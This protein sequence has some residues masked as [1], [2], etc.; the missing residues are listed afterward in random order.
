VISPLTG[1]TDADAI[2]AALRGGYLFDIGG[3]KAGPMLG[4]RHTRTR[5]DGY[6]E[7]GDPALAILVDRQTL[8]STTSDLGAEVHVALSDRVDGFAGIAWRHEFGDEYR[9]LT[10]RLAQSPLLPIGTSVQNFEG[11]DHGVVTGGLSFDVSANMS[12]TLAGAA[13]FA[14]ESGNN[15]QIDASLG[16]RSKSVS[17]SAATRAIGLF[18]CVV[19]FA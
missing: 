12:A 5:V 1:S 8:S 3:V 16:I 10:T 18:G 4:F 13:T 15:F 14:R 6:A 9:T 19:Q 11:R 7:G 17:Y 2:S